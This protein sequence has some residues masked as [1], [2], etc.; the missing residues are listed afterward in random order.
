MNYRSLLPALLVSLSAEAQPIAL[1]LPEVSWPSALATLSDGGSLLAFQTGFPAYNRIV[2]LGA[3]GSTVWSVDVTASAEALWGAVEMANGDILTMAELP[4][5]A[6]EGEWVNG[7]IRLDAGGAIVRAVAFPSMPLSPWYRFGSY[8]VTHGGDLGYHVV[9]YTTSGPQVVYRMSSEDELL[10][11]FATTPDQ[12]PA[13]DMKEHG[14][15]L[16]GGFDHALCKFTFDGT[17]VWRKQRPIS[18]RCI[19]KSLRF[20]GD[21]L[22]IAAQYLPGDERRPAILAYDTTGA[23]LNQLIFDMPGTGNYPECVFSV[24]DNGPVLFLHRGYNTYVFA[25]DNALSQWRVFADDKV[26]STVGLCARTAANTLLMFYS[27]NANGHGLL[28]ESDAGA[29]LLPCWNDTLVDTLQVVIPPLAPDPATAV[30]STP[31]TATSTIDAVAVPMVII[32]DCINTGVE[33]VPD[34]LL[35]ALVGDHLVIDHSVS[36][37][38]DVSVLD[39]AGRLLLRRTGTGHRMELSVNDAPPSALMV[40][41]RLPDGRVFS[42]KIV[43]LR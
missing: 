30:T 31:N 18:P 5:T 12:L 27:H 19:Y 25:S 23:L 7:I 10:T 17:V 21:T 3:N 40:R 13:H 11:A 1:D 41:V 20:K 9:Y 15:Y 43:L 22:W 28:H 32:P 29:Y 37:L 16:Y 35:I 34:E 24:L 6:N 4:D 8:I 38:A 36:I 2:R 26:Y 39:P 42:R 33:L 14:G